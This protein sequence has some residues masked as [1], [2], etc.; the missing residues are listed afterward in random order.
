VDELTWLSST[1]PQDMLDF[2]KGKASDRKLRLF[3]CACRRQ[4]PTLPWI[5]HSQGWQHMEN[6]P[7]EPVAVE[8][9]AN[10]F[11]P[12]L[13]HA[14][15][16]LSEHFDLEHRPSP[17][18]AAS[19]L[20]EIISNPFRP[21]P[22]VR[23][24][25]GLVNNHQFKQVACKHPTANGMRIGPYY[26][27]V[28]GALL[29]NGTLETVYPE[30]CLRP[31]NSY[32]YNTMFQPEK[33]GVGLMRI[34]WLTDTV[35]ALAEPIYNEHAFDRLPILAD[36]LQEAGCD[37]EDILHHCRGQERCPTCL[38]HGWVPRPSALWHL[39]CPDCEG[40]GW[41]P[42]RGPHV[43]GCWVLDHLLGYS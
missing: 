18:L 9:N 12:A 29:P 37:L 25:G 34:G 19:L 10:H 33:K 26:G 11:I 41:L 17:A 6:H 30:G 5:G 36:A 43:R 8:G 21:L 14:A 23:A 13:E 2:V 3:A 20:R 40:T 22:E 16:F 39:T 31:W 15:L 32:R 42:L 38:G 28:D 1:T 24:F 27:H 4:V 7:E 35:V